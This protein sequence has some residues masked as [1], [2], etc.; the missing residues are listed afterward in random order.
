MR[1][2]RRRYLPTLLAGLVVVPLAGVVACAPDPIRIVS[3]S[4]SATE[5]L[6]AIDLGE[7]VVAADNQSDHP[8]EA[9]DEEDLSGFQPDSSL[10]AE[11]DP[12]VVV[13]ANDVQDARGGRII[14]NL[15]KLGIKVLLQSAPGS[16]DEL[17]DQVT[18]LGEE[19]SVQESAK[20]LVRRIDSEIRSISAEAPAGSKG[21]HYYHEVDTNYYTSTSKTFV[22]SVYALFGL[23]N[24]ADPLDRAGTGFP[25]LTDDDV[26]EANPDLIF[27]ADTECC[28]QSIATVRSRPGW[29]KITAVR[30]GSVI[31]LDDDL[32]SRWGPR[33]V[34]LARAIAAALR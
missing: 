21:L 3:L 16:L 12:D 26:I 9:P 14:A 27:L 23:R 7:Q 28:G 6:F 33:V 8:P 2:A 20:A 19:L 5:T 30:T 24:I 22:G 29:L 1:V 11:H 17:Y 4:P 31:P 10:I 32:A 34:D 15:E 18:R 13:L 25:Q